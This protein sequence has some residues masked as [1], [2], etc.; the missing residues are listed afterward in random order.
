MCR[1]HLITTKQNYTTRSTISTTWGKYSTILSGFSSLHGSQHKWMDEYVLLGNLNIHINKKND[2][3]TIT[4]LKT[5]KRFGLQNRVEFPTHQL[6]N[7]LDLIITEENSYIIKETGR[8]S[9]ISDHNIIHFIFQTPSKTT[10]MKQVSY[11]K[12]KS[13]DIS[14]LLKVKS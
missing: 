4:L 11:W 9:L 12:T 7:T 5:L 6:Q 1:F 3:D 2:Q 10:T 8:W 14:L 13:I